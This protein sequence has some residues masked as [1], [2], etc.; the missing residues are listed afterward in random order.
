VNHA[1]QV[2]LA[3]APQSVSNARRVAAMHDYLNDHH[4]VAVQIL[5]G[6]VS[7]AY[8]YDAADGVLASSQ[9]GC[10]PSTILWQLA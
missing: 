5:S 6:G 1:R 3:G 7:F 9:P 4:D 10:W 8:G 2:D